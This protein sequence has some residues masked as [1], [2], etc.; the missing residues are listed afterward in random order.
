MLKYLNTLV[1][2]PQIILLQ[3]ML[4]FSKI[5]I[6]K[7]QIFVKE[8]E[9]SFGIYENIFLFEMEF[10]NLISYSADMY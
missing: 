7:E 4:R 8:C 1:A 5:R 9:E 3:E 2:S 10:S 6:L